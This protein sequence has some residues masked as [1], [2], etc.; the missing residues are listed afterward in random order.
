MLIS[1]MIFSGLLEVR[2]AEHERTKVAKLFL[3][4]SDPSRSHRDRRALNVQI[5]I[6]HLNST[7]SNYSRGLNSN[8]YRYF[9]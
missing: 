3:R 7:W 8:R 6:S 5:L 4:G 2:S 1:N 9:H